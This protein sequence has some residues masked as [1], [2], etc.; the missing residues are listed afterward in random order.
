MV[1]PP[2]PPP[3]RRVVTK[4]GISGMGLSTHLIL[5]VC[6]GGCWLPVW[7]LH[8][9]FTRSKKVTTHY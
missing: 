4:G 7:F 3:P 5:S 9:L 6:T 8:W 2:P 1:S